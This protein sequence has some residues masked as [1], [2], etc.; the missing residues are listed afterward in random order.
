[1]AP[2]NV[3]VTRLLVLVTVA[4]F[5]L[6]L[7]V[8]EQLSGVF[9][10]GLWMFGRSLWMFGPRM[11]P[12]LYF[13]SVL[14]AAAAQLVFSAYSDVRYP[15]IGASGGIFG[16]LLAYG[17]CFPRRIIVLLIPPLP[18]PAWLA[19]VLY[20]A[21]ELTLVISNA[22][23]RQSGRAASRQHLRPRRAEAGRPAR[24]AA[25]GCNAARPMNNSP[26]CINMAARSRRSIKW[27]PLL[28]HGRRRNR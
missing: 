13:A 19:V 7:M 3:S 6:E 2:S 10:L 15:A 26:P 25:I 4:C 20:A 17:V 14:S 1:M 21:L 8:G 23:A 22:R 5:L 18:L 12:A 28:T 9:A 24:R 27:M 16:V 11:L